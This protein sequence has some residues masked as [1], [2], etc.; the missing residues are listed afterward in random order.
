MTHR[1]HP[2]TARLSGWLFPSVMGT[3]VSRQSR[4]LP[5]AHRV[6]RRLRQRN[7][8][9]AN[10]N[11]AGQDESLKTAHERMIQALRKNDAATAISLYAGDVVF[12]APNDQ[13]I[14][15]K[16]E[17]GEWWKEYFAHFTIRN[18]METERHVQML[19]DWSVV[20][21]CYQVAIHPKGS[22][23]RILDEGRGLA[24]WN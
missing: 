20:R 15:G 2:G 9:E 24:I 22:G 5:S 21:W 19:G 14:Y 16:E 6:S 23:E 11:D 7:L 12:M 8:R 10:M 18:L 13:S 1:S 3:A 4:K 17:V